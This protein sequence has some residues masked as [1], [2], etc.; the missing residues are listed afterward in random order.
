MLRTD[1]NQNWR[2]V[3]PI[4]FSYGTDS[5]LI[6]DPERTDQVSDKIREFYFNNEEVSMA[7]AQNLTNL[8]SDALFVRGIHK[9]ALLLAK[10]TPVYTGMFTYI[11]GGYSTPSLFGITEVLGIYLFLIPS[12]Y[13]V[14]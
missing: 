6:G 13:F 9:T 8:Y 1:M 2:R 4:T 5:E 10:N 12:S 3:A 11:G 7:N 14:F